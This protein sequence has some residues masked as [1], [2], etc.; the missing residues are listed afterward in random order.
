[1]IW[2]LPSQFRFAAAPVRQNHTAQQQA[3]QAAI[4]MLNIHFTLPDI[5]LVCQA[6]NHSK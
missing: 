4:L 3:G 2:R 6:N 5:S 1:M